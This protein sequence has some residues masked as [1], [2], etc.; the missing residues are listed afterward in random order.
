DD[1]PSGLTPEQQAMIDAAANNLFASSA[2]KKNKTM[3][4]EKKSPSGQG[5]DVDLS[6]LDNVDGI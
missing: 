1:G 5:Q 6:S 2:E 4:Q 3:K